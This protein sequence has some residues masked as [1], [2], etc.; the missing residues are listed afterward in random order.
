MYAVDNK[1]ADQPARSAPLL[2]A[3]DIN[4]FSHDVAHIVASYQ[5]DPVYNVCNYRNDPKFSDKQCRPWSWSW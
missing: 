5:G 4:R 1:G 2:F 3:A